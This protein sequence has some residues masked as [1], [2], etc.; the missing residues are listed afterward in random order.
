MYVIYNKFNFLHYKL[1]NRI[2]QQPPIKKNYNK[3]QICA[4]LFNTLLTPQP[5]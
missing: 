5:K 1:T 2:T 4:N 3:L